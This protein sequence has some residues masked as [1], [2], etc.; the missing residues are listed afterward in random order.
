MG[1][2]KRQLMTLFVAVIAVV[3][4]NA[5]ESAPGLDKRFGT[6]YEYLPAPVNTV[7]QAASTA[8]RD[9]GLQVISEQSTSSGAKIVARN[10]FNTKIII[11]A[12][13]AGPES[14]KVGVRVDP[15]ENEGLS[16]SVIQKIKAN[17]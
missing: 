9:M 2:I 10:S 6:Y 15:G 11:T 8:V 3:A 7:A 17:L 13:F 1:S 12:S 14:T 5:C 16:L 4:L